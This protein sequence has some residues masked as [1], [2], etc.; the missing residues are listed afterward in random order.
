MISIVSFDYFP[1]FEYIPVDFSEVWTWSPEFEW[2]GYDTV[3]FLLGLGS[4]AVFAFFQILTVIFS[5]ILPLCICRCNRLREK[6]SLTKAWQGSL[7]F[8][9]GTFFEILVCLSISVGMLSYW[10]YFNEADHASV[11]LSLFF[12]LLMIGYLF[13]V[14][15][16]ALFRSK[17]LAKKHRAE[18]EEN[19]LDK[20]ELIHD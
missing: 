17:M 3:N 15:F 6:F 5:L 14:L 11:L 12:M 4:I 9:H 13:T 10:E 18:C 20:T 1:P 16:F 7:T 8:L 2:I 19:V